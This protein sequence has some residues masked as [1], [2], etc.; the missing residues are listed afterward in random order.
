MVLEDGRATNLYISVQPS[1]AVFETPLE[2]SFPN[3]DRLAANSEVYLMSFDHD[4]GRY[5]R[6]GS[7]HVTADAQRVVSDPGS[8]I[9]VGA[10]HALPPP[11]PR[12]EVTVL[13]QIKF[14][15]NPALENKAIEMLKHGSRVRALPCSLQQPT[16]IGGILE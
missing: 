16:P 13:G 2:V 8:G 1:G 12:P 14:K 5:V 10:W 4:A 11:D 7:G 3:I 9:R 6:V 15:G